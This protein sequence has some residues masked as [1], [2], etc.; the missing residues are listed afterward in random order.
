MFI[1]TIFKK[2]NCLH[3]LNFSIENMRCLGLSDVP[4]PQFPW[5]TYPFCL[6]TLVPYG[7]GTLMPVAAP[8]LSMW[9]TPGQS[10]HYTS[11]P[12]LPPGPRG[13][14]RPSR[15]NEIPF[16]GFSWKCKE[17]RKWD[18]SLELLSI[19][20]IDTKGK[21]PTRNGA[22]RGKHSWVEGKGTLVLTTDSAVPEAYSCT[23]QWFEPLNS[24]S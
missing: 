18:E 11:P 6:Y 7:L 14:R 10:E 20:H 22:H 24:P 23:F 8:G 3:C 4:V 5:K 12:P 21:E 9:P 16:Q 17:L 1:K 13:A 15:A 19:S 2:F